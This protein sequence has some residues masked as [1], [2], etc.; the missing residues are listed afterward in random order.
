[1]TTYHNNRD[2]VVNGVVS[3][4]LTLLLA[5]VIGGFVAIATVWLFAVLFP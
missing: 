1:M 5:L 2:S 3:Q 4:V